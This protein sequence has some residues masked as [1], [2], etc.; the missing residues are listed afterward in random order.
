LD[1]RFAIDETCIDCRLCQDL[2]PENF[3]NDFD[4]DVHYVCKQPETNDELECALDAAGSC[5]TGSI[6]YVALT[7]GE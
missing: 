7:P 5:P 2:A 6:R 4:N 1:G 3:D